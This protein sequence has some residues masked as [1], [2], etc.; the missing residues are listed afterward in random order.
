M[1]CTHVVIYRSPLL[2]AKNIQRQGIGTMMVAE[3]T[4]EER[5]SIDNIKD[6]AEQ[7]RPHHVLV[8]KDFLSPEYVTRRFL[9]EVNHCEQYVHRVKVGRFKK[10]GSVRRE[11]LKRHAPHLH[12]LYYSNKLKRFIEGVIGAPLYRCPEWDQHAVALYYYTEPGDRIGVHYDKSFYR[13]DRI[14]VLIGMVQDSWQSKLMC[15]LGAT[16]LNR[17]KNPTEVLTTPGTLVAFN[18]DKL[19]HEVTPLGENER[20][21]ILTME[22]LTDTRIS[23]VNRFISDMKDRYLYF[24]K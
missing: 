20:R 11:L 13:G 17:R 16:K 19:W 7:Y 24:G 4:L 12:S 18:G 22:F 5:I 23:K 14:T 6:Y 21:V 10:S 3:P 15:Y 9:P 8:V 1:R 2:L